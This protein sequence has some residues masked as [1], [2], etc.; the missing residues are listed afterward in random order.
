MN[1]HFHLTRALPGRAGV[2]TWRWW[3]SLLAA[4]WLGTLTAGEVQWFGV[5][6]L[7]QFTQLP[8]QSPGPAAGQP[9]FLALALGQ[10]PQTLVSGTVQ[11]PRGAPVTLEVVTN[12]LALFFEQRFAT[13]AALDA[14]Y[15]HGSLL[16]PGTYPFHLRTRSGEHSGAVSYAGVLGPPP[17][18]EVIHLEAAAAVDPALPFTL[19]WK[20]PGG[21]ILDLILVVILD[22]SSN[23]VF[24]SPLPFSEGALNGLATEVQIPA[25]ALPPAATLEGHVLIARPGLPNTTSIPGAIGIAALARET[26]FPL[27]TRPLPAPPRLEWVIAPGEGPAW[28]V[29]APPHRT[30]HFL[31][32]DDLRSWVEMLATNLPAGVGE[33]RDPGATTR[34][35]RFYRAVLP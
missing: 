6:K 16:N 35:R 8:G 15:P 19:R 27:A 5:V 10:A 25:H 26:S 3:C 13:A 2:E 17:V 29:W 22:A 30:V 32:S 11:P 9:Y 20:V 34:P 12:G 21:T 1:R 31:A 7:R 23:V 28:R 14:A 24:S 33:V 4:G 18:P